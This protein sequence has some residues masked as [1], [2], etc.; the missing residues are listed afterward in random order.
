MLLLFSACQLWSG[1]YFG[2]Q[3][4]AHVLQGS[5]SDAERGSLKNTHVRKPGFAVCY[6]L[7]QR[8]DDASKIRHRVTQRSADRTGRPNKGK[9]EKS[10]ELNQVCSKWC[11]V[12]SENFC[13]LQLCDLHQDDSNLGKT[14]FCLMRAVTNKRSPSPR[15][16]EHVEGT[17]LPS[18]MRQKKKKKG[19]GIFF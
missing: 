6:P 19:V 14:L 16:L 15:V 13:K 18:S 7:T 10:G 1:C 11:F 5:I 4:F 12:S 2:M 3:D 8:R 17:F 9:S